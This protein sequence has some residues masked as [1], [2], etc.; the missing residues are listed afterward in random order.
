MDD[1]VGKALLE[2]LEQ[3]DFISSFFLFEQIR[4]LLRAK[5][6]TSSL[7]KAF[8]QYIGNREA[9]LLYHEKHKIKKEDFEKVWWDGIESALKIFPKIFQ[10]WLAFF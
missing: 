9:K 6:L 2:G 8:E 1:L 10:V 5:K 3:H 4:I 7:K